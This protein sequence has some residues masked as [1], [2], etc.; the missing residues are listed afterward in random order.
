[1]QLE[2][3]LALIVPWEIDGGYIRI[4]WHR[5]DTD[6]WHGRACQTVEDILRILEAIK[7]NE[8]NIFICLSAQSDPGRRFAK[9]A[10]GMSGIWA[11]ADVKP[12][13]EG[14]Y[15]TVNEAISAILNFCAA[16]GIPL[17]S[18]IVRSGGGVHA[19]WL[20]KIT[21]LVDKWRQFANGLK[22][23]AL[24]AEP[25]LLIDTAVTIDAARI[26]RMPG[27]LNCKY[28][29]PVLVEI[30]QEQSPGRKYDFDV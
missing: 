20:S 17:P 3:F 23:A 21:L 13:K 6:K 12:G 8:Y 18:I 19:Y 30:E 11:D 22:A 25:R 14:H 7:N 4:E 2:E 28:T 29:P 26:L 9:N 5:P 24:Q 27:T 10:L 15:A 16:I 1:M